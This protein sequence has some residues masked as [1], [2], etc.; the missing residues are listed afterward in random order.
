M[1]VILLSSG[2]NEGKVGT[3]RDLARSYIKMDG[4]HRCWISRLLWSL[5][6]AHVGSKESIGPRHHTTTPTPT[7]LG[8][9]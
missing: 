9:G 5:E 7:P 4:N 6:A 2:S 3:G 1:F 8:M